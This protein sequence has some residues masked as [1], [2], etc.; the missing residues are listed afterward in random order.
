MTPMTH[1]GYAAGVEYSEED[2]CFIGRV[3][4]IKPIIT[5][6]GDSVD[7]LRERF[8]DA[9]DFYLETCAEQGEKPDK[10]FSGNIMAR[11]GPDL[12][13]R[14]KSMAEAHGQSLNRFVTDAIERAV[15]T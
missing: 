6:H 12:H 14:A 4:G 8:H 11:V 5:F 9:V 15:N 2:G 3:A 7:E 1:K 10:P 13:A